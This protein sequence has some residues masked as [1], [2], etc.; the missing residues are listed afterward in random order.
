M[1]RIRAGPFLF[2]NNFVFFFVFFSEKFHLQNASLRIAPFTIKFDMSSR[3]FR[4][5]IFMHISLHM[6][7]HVYFNFYTQS[8]SNTHMPFSCHKYTS[9][10]LKITEWRG[11]TTVA[12]RCIG[13][14]VESELGQFF[15]LAIISFLFVFFWENFNLRHAYI[16]KAVFI[17]VE[18]ENENENDCLVQYSFYF[19]FLWSYSFP[20]TTRPLNHSVYEWFLT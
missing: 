16:R 6:R 4:R 11:G 2:V 14:W 5:W 13:W 3:N 8:A 7:M 18:Y 1:D 19:P 9:T 10:K 17:S 12:Y 20:E 15:F